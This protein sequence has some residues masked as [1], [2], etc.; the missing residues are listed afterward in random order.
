MLMLVIVGLGMAL[1]SR[2]QQQAVVRALQ[3]KNAERVERQ[4]FETTLAS[5]GDAVIVTDAIGHVTFSNKV[6]LSLTGWQEDE[7]SRQGP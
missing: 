4:R 7:A 1:L 6:A 3:A 2:S 5:I